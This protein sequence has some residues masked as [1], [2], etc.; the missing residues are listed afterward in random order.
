M[1]AR[2]HILRPPLKIFCC[3]CAGLVHARPMCDAAAGTAPRPTALSQHRTPAASWSARSE[4]CSCQLFARSKFTASTKPI[5]F[6]HCRAV[7]HAMSHKMM[8]C[9]SCA[10]PT[11]LSVWSGPPT[12]PPLMT[13][14]AALLDMKL[15]TL[16]QPSPDSPAQH[17][18]FSAALQ[19]PA[20]SRMRDEHVELPSMRGCV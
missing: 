3:A 7:L 17:V 12:S 15:C 13:V 19:G 16:Q 11:Y 18:P 4:Y 10:R 9:V 1:D 20:T 2:Q 5:V 8:C 6:S 14:T